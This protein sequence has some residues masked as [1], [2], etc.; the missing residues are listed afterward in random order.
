[1]GDGMSMLDKL[2]ALFRLDG[3]FGSHLAP[4]DR[5]GEA[6]AAQRAYY[7]TLSRQVPEHH[8]HNAGPDDISDPPPVRLDPA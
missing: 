2:H 7:A 1:M 8:R 4:R 5:I 6:L 3:L